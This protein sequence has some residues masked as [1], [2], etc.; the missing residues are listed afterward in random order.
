MLKI[1]LAWVLTCTLLANS[2][3][4][5]PTEAMQCSFQQHDA[6]HLSD[7][8]RASAH[9]VSD[10][11]EDIWF[12]ASALPSSKCKGTLASSEFM[13]SVTALTTSLAKG[14]P[15][16]QEH[17]MSGCS[18]KQ[19]KPTSR[20]ASSFVQCRLHAVVALQY[21]QSSA[22]PNWKPRQRSILSDVPPQ[23]PLT[24]SRIRQW[25]QT[26]SLLVILISGIAGIVMS[27]YHVGSDKCFQPIATTCYLA[28]VLLLCWQPN[29]ARTAVA[30]GL[31]PVLG[32]PAGLML[33]QIWQ[34]YSVLLSASLPMQVCI[35]IG[36]SSLLYFTLGYQ[37]IW[38]CKGF[39]ALLYASTCV[40]QAVLP[41]CNSILPYV[42]AVGGIGVLGAKSIMACFSTISALTGNFIS[43][44]LLAA[45]H[46]MSPLWIAIGTCVSSNIY[47]LLQEV[48]SVLAILVYLV[49]ALC[50]VTQSGK[51]CTSSKLARWFTVTCFYIAA[52]AVHFDFVFP[53]VLAMLLIIGGIEANP[54]PAV[55]ILAIIAMMITSPRPTRYRQNATGPSAVTL[56]S[57]KTA[58]VMISDRLVCYDHCRSQHVW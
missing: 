32:W 5:R 55:N 28:H 18:N 4:E 43:S 29:M 53:L 7:G 36:I 37:V 24:L 51:S 22:K 10:S 49:L 23:Q 38:N 27:Q 57:D 34:I 40:L 46:L 44:I 30:V 12:T 14:S 41:F 2:W 56:T 15:V 11:W 54:G 3:P 26:T 50:V 13:Q 20:F 35:V 8:S 58:H 31:L 47:L 21:F 1:T 6:Q 52:L 45:K 39:A 19:P 25:L 17:L 9:P 33:S 42:C 48:T 16:C